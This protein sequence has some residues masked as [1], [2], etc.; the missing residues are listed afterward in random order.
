MTHEELDAIEARHQ[1]GP[2]DIVTTLHDVCALVAALREAWAQIAALEARVE[3]EV[4]DRKCALKELKETLD[5]EDEA[6]ELTAERARSWELAKEVERLRDLVKRLVAKLPKER[7]DYSG[8]GWCAGC[9]AILW[10]SGSP[11]E[12]RDSCKPDCVL[13]EALNEIAKWRESSG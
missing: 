1:H 3:R 8:V 2:V 7:K 4:E 9:G 5:G 10:V 6:S 12:P 13:Q 11:G